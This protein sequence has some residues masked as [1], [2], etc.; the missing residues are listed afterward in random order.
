ML[1]RFPDI[2]LEDR[3][4]MTLPEDS[5][6]IH[7]YR[8]YMDSL[9]PRAG[10]SLES[11]IQAHRTLQFQWRSAI[12]SARQDTRVLG[13]LYRQVDAAMCEAVPARNNHKMCSPKGWKYELPCEPDEQAKQLLAEHRRLVRQI[14]FIREPVER[15]GD[16][17]VARQRTEYE[18]LII[19]AWD[20]T[21]AL[22]EELEMFLAE[23]VHDSVA[24]FTDWSC[25]L[26]DQRGIFCDRSK[27]LA[28]INQTPAVPVT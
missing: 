27:Y 24:H 9:L 21:T 16:I 8:A 2:K 25:A 12:T 26:Y 13:A 19:R 4:E 11:L 10:N 23:H 1:Q 18:D 7:K 6:L 22:P 14:P 20:S 15:Q 5:S 17:E 3:A 28:N